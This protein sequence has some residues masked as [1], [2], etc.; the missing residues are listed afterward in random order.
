MPKPS[1]IAYIDESGDEGFAFDRN[2]SQWFVLGAAV[3][4]AA[5]ELEQVKLVD[6]VRRAINAAWS[7]AN[8]GK[9]QRIADK[10]ALHFKDL[11]HEQRRYYVS[12]IA[13]A[14]VR[15]ASVLIDKTRLTSPENFQVGNRLYHWG[16]RVLVERI[17]WLCRDAPRHEADGGNGTVRLVFS[18]RSTMNY[19]EL[20]SY[21]RHLESNRE[22]LDYRADTSV[23][24]PDQ[25][26]TYTS[27][28]R[29][30]LQIADAIASSLFQAVTLN[31]YGLTE[32]SY[33]L[34][35]RP[36]SYRHQG[37]VWGYGIKILPAEAEEARRRGELFPEW[38]R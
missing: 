37:T 30:G 33:T 13:Q 17:S 15:L 10:A 34:A 2:S 31:R 18:N 14:R 12:R 6:D 23:V 8:P 5:T 11:K 16:I 32:P 4:R 27:G 20:A 3:F 19:S 26:E 24:R 36:V 21:L 22:A 35:L 9:G 25:V 29:M 38:P 28:R 7:E 1:F